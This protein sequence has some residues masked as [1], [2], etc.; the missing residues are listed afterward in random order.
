MKK[1]MILA[2][3]MM[4]ACTTVTTIGQVRPP[5]PD[6]EK[7]EL[8]SAGVGDESLTMFY[9]R[10]NSISLVAPNVYK[11]WMRIYEFED[12]KWLPGYRLVLFEV[13][14]R[15]KRWRLKQDLVYDEKDKQDE[16]K[17]VV[18]DAKAKWIDTQPDTALDKLFE[19]VCQRGAQ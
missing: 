10:K 11:F 8:A 1:L 6:P 16:T 15:V 17:S 14:C 19:G 4:I 7:W 5:K 2:A 12:R 9:L 3:A 18:D 13:D